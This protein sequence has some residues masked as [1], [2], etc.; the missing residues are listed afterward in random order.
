M[1]AACALA[2]LGCGGSSDDASLEQAD[3]GAAGAEP[4]VTVAA[5]G[6]AGAGD[7]VAA[8]EAGEGSGVLTTGVTVRSAS[9]LE[10]GDRSVIRTASLEVRTA[11]VA[12][13]SERAL[14]VAEA[15]GGQLSSQQSQLEGDTTATLVFK[16]PPEAFARVLADLADLGELTSRE[17][18]SDDVT[19]EVVDLEGRLAAVTASVER[20]RALLAQAADVPQVVAV[21]G[22][23]A[24][25]EGELE[26]L[27]G[28]LRA[29]RA[30]VDLATVTLSLREPPPVVGEEAEVS[31]DIPG[32]MRGLRT[33]AVVFVN[34]AQAVVTG[35]GFVLPFLALAL[36]VGLPLRWALL[37]RRR[38][39]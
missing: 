13:T 20:L 4:Q 27:T 38:P 11:D 30:Q 7:A 6:A 26:S 29:L 17:V 33:G 23:L 18:G 2:L 16:V 22:E 5:E 24:R 14:A 8:D 37:R 25:R 21:E 1:A 32:F 28:Q 12:E 34:V 31:D 35:V 36:L 10:G 39:A 9:Q 19:T 15:A 3:T